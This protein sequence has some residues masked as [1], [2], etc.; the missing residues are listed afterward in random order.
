M[1]TD[2]V[3]DPLTFTSWR[4][5]QITLV[6]NNLQKPERRRRHEAWQTFKRTMLPAADKGLL[7]WFTRLVFILHAEWHYRS[8]L[9]NILFMDIRLESILSV[10]SMGDFQYAN[11]WFLASSLHLW[12]GNR[13]TSTIRVSSNPLNSPWGDEE[14]RRRKHRCIVCGGLSGL[15]YKCCTSTCGTA[16]H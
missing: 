4:A 6:N 11:L 16:R 5:I 1:L 3:T 10:E 12:P 9:F 13:S 2:W 14:L 7:V 8:S 15:R